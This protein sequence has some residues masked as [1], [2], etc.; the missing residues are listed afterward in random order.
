MGY[1]WTGIKPLICNSKAVSVAI[2][3]SFV[4]GLIS[5]KI[6]LYF[7]LHNLHNVGFSTGS[8]ISSLAQL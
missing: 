1:M 7:F 8:A 2:S 5:H 6:T 3:P 4:K